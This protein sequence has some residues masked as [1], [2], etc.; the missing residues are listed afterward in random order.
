MILRNM[1]ELRELNDDNPS[2]LKGKLY[3]T[4][5]DGPDREWSGFVAAILAG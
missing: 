2:M 4:L 5:S 1:R 3:H